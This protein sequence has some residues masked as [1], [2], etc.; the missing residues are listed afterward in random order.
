MTFI[1][2]RSLKHMAW[3]AMKRKNSRF[4]REGNGCSLAVREGFAAQIPEGEPAGLY[5]LPVCFAN[6]FLF[7]DAHSS[8]RL[9]SP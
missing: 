9:G 2:N 6:G 5:P 4:Q 3:F 1:L 8:L 7:S